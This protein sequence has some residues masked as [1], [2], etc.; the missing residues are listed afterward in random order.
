MQDLGFGVEVLENSG[1]IPGFIECNMTHEFWILS[2][3]LQEALS[4][5]DATRKNL[6]NP[7]CDFLGD[8]I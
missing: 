1:E 2:I 3:C 6:D 4:T 8:I 5:P 7:D